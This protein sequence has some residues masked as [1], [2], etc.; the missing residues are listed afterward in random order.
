[1]PPLLS[2]TRRTVSLALP[3]IVGHV[4]QMLMGWVDTIMV[5]R[6][7]VVPLAACGFANTLLSVPLVFGFGLLSAVSVQVSHAHGAGE[8]PRAAGSVRGGFVMAA[9]LCVGSLAAIALLHPRLALFG[10][11]VEVNGAVGGY[12][13]ICAWSLVAVFFSTVTKNFCEALARP[14]PPF[15]I[16]ISG[17]GLNALLNWILIFGNWG[18]PALG[19]EGA[20]WA[21][22]VSRIVVMV[23]LLIYPAISTALRDSWPGRWMAPG[24]WPAAKEALAIGLPAGGLHLFEVSGFALASLMMGWISVAALAAHQIALTC[25]ATTFMVPL[26]LSQAVCVRVGH[27]RGGNRPEKLR[28]IVLGALCLTVVFMGVTGLTL[29]LS[30]RTIASWF[31]TD[32][33]VLL[34]TAQLLAIGGIFQIVDG[35]QV[36]S[37][38]ALRGFGDTRV[39]MGIGILSYW[40]VALPVSYVAAFGLGAGAQGVW[41]GLVVGLTVAAAAFA[42]RLKKMVRRASSPSPGIP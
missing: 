42:I 37:A 29:F 40:L 32:P 38:G 16:M 21:T 18:A 8:A 5:G 7:G 36:V 1:M 22:L 14:W 41:A 27:A 11:P 10:Q 2:E 24:A 23:A 4:G 13:A 9:L 20:G 12:L 39:P 30:G 25:V 17:V 19:L 6:V 33:P 34:L 26:G 35:I 31:V 3:I 28:P 15:W